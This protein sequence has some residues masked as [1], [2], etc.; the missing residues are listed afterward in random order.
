MAPRYVHVLSFSIHVLTFDYSLIS[1][2]IDTIVVSLQMEGE[3]VDY[4]QDLKSSDSEGDCLIP[5]LYGMEPCGDVA[6][7]PGLPQFYSS[8]CVHNKYCMSLSFVKWGELVNK[9]LGGG[10]G[11][12]GQG[13][14]RLRQ[15]ADCMSVSCTAATFEDSIED[16]IDSHSDV[17]SEL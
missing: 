14:S 9:L 17:S 4:H 7:F 6:L 15:D 2:D 12:G 1:A 8:H 5:I 16:L 11:G 13:E 3:D 10:G